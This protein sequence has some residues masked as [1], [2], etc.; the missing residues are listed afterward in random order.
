M[1]VYGDPGFEENLSVLLAQLRERIA[2]AT[3]SDDARHDLL[4]TLRGLLIFAGQIEQAVW[5]DLP[6]LIDANTAAAFLSLTKHV[7]SEL[8]FAFHAAWTDAAHSSPSNSWPRIA[9]ILN[10]VQ[11]MLDTSAVLSSP[12]TSAARLRVTLPEGYA[13]YALYPEQYARAAQNWSDHA[14]DTQASI[15]VV[16]I[17]SIGTSLAALVSRTLDHKGGRTVSLTTRPTGHPFARYIQGGLPDTEGVEYALI[18]DE[19]PGMSGSSMSAVAQALAKAGMEA[20]HVAFLPGHSGHPGGQGSDEVKRWWA[21]TPRFV[22]SSQDMRWNGLS[23]PDILAER[24]CSLLGS[25]YR[26]EDMRVEDFGGGLWR[27]AA[28]TTEAEWPAACTAFEMPKYRVTLPDGTRIL[29]KFAGLATGADGADQAQ[30]VY[31]KLRQRSQAGWTPGPLGT[32]MGFVAVRWIDA[33]PL[34]YADA[35]ADILRHIG[36]YIAAVAGPPLSHKVHVASL[37]RLAD[38]LYWNTWETLGEEPAARTR[39]WSERAKNADWLQ[40]APTYGDGR[41]APHKWLRLPDGTL[42]KTD[43]AGHD[44]DHT[45]VGK[46]CWL[47]DIAG[48]VVEWQLAE[49]E[50][51]TMLNAAEGNLNRDGQSVPSDILTFYRMAY[52]AFRA[53][54]TQLCAQMSAHDPAEQA[55]L[56]QAYS[57]YK[58]QLRRLLA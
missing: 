14:P 13:F 5:D 7:T 33:P 54:Q 37:T 1:I 12:A 6:A 36:R 56:W 51:K 28:Y 2:A 44:A 48:A 30:A 24:T 45:V 9:Q 57:H 3:I 41:M 27:R 22:T 8:A 35:N 38:M 15:A 19:G 31:Q 20:E 43:S 17:R 50:A 40:P 58:E 52:A 55:R 49:A 21:A 16:G 34:T 10:G 39:M 26:I 18:V 23:L 47:W 46:Q 53:G 32:V 4:D 25:D 29:W 42:L 11:A